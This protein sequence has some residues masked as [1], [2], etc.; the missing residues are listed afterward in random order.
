MTEKVSFRANEELL[1]W[2]DDYVTETDHNKSDLLR[3]HLEALREDKLYRDF[4]E[5]R[6]SDG[7]DLAG[8]LESADTFDSKWINMEEI[9][10]DEF[11]SSFKDIIQS[12]QRGHINEAY[13]EVDDLGDSGM[14]REALLLNQVVSEY[15]R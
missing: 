10:Y 14:E 8:Y 2:F 12:A 15:D 9:K 1:E 6:I 4:H 7:K 11:Y 13:E 5:E 3:S